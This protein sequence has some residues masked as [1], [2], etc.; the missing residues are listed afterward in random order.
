MKKRL[1]FLA[2]LFVCCLLVIWLAVAVAGSGRGV[3][4]PEVSGYDP[5]V[6][7]MRHMVAAAEDGSPWAL[8]RG[9]IYEK[10]RNAKIADLKMDYAKTNYF[11]SGDNSKMILEK[12]REYN[13]PHPSPAATPSPQGEGKERE[14][15]AAQAEPEMVYRGLYYITGYDTCYQCC[16]KTD[17]ITAS[18]TYATVG[19]TVAAS[20]EFAFGTRLWIDGLG[21]RVVEDRGG[22]IGGGRLDLVCS[23]HDEC[24]SITGWYDVWVI[25][26]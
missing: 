21:E 25:V 5:N 13:T 15:A 11:G 6:D 9:E 8:A 26:G 4:V 16:G 12:L 18:G 23:D 1:I 7:S 19:R 17:G 10:C 3:Y 24:Y 14:D 20:S 2:V 22:A